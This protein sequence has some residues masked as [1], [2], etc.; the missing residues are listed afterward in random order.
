MMRWWRRLGSAA[1]A[2][3]LLAATLW[4]SA[5]EP[6]PAPQ[7]LAEALLQQARDQGR[8]LA[9]QLMGAPALLHAGAATIAIPFAAGT[10]LGGYFTLGDRRASAPGQI[11]ALAIALAAG[12]QRLVLVGLDTVTITPHLSEAIAIAS[13]DLG[14]PVLPLA[15]HTHSGPGGLGDRWL[16]SLFLGASDPA[17][18]T[19]LAAGSADAARAA[20]ANLQPVQL[21][22][23][24]VQTK[25]LVINRSSPGQL[26]DATLDVVALLGGQGLVGRLVAFGAHP[27]LVA[28]RDQLDGDYPE[29][30]RTAL[31]GA[32]DATPTL[33][34]AAA[35]GSSS[36]LR[37]AG[38]QPATALGERLAAIVDHELTLTVRGS[39]QA[40]ATAHVE[41]AMPTPRFPISR[42]RVL[43]SWLSR[44]LVPATVG[45]DLVRIGPVLIAAIPGELSAEVTPTLRQQFARAGLHLVIASHNGQYAGYFM[46][47]ERYLQPGP[48]AA[49]ELYGPD[50]ADLF[51]GLLQGIQ[52]GLMIGT[53]EK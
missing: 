8:Q 19:L 49:L 40:L 43:R 35:T 17:V 1:A 33:F 53:A 47:A 10:P 48:E 20:I 4:F 11:A 2:L 26:I 46:P 16:E 39:T 52:L 27:T 30:L 31:A 6:A 51:V 14:A 45:V 50:T 32:G 25:D 37:I 28:T 7:S 18:V 15:T 3:A 42:T 41:L 21:L 22:D 12:E 13:T 38:Q 34:A 44:R 24:A 5:T 29:R 9:P 23:G 36:A